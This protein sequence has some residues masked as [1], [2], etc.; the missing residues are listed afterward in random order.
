MVLFMN[1]NRY[2]GVRVEGAKYGVGF[3]SALA[4]AMSY[5]ANHS[6]LWAIFPRNFR[7]A[8]RSLLRVVSVMIG[9]RAPRH[10]EA[11][12]RAKPHFGLS[13]LLLTTDSTRTRD[14]GPGLPV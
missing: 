4:I 6:I 12:P 11:S 13:S 3:G 9:A 14:V 8:L 10:L 1:G 2:Y 5:T 7:L